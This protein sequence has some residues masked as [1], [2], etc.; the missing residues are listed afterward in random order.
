MQPLDIH[1]LFFHG[2]HIE[3]PKWFAGRQGDIEKALKSLCSPGSSMLVFGERGVGKSS[4]IEMVK[5]IASG[6]NH[7]LFKYNL[8]KLYPPEKFKYRI[9]SVTCD[10]DCTTTAKVLQRLIT[11]PDG[12]K[13]IVSLRQEKIEST[14]KDKFSLDFLKLFTYGT[15]EEKK[16]TSSEIKEDSIFE[17]FINII[18]SISKNVINGNEG[19]LIAIDEF[20]LVSDSSKMASLIK[21]LSKNNVKFLISGIAE[22]YEQLIS[23]HQS[24]FRQLVYG[25]IEI[26]KMTI[27]EVTE[28]FKNVEINSNKRI[29]FDDSFIK[30]VFEK[31]GGYPY[32]VQLLGQLALDNYVS[33]KGLNPPFLFHPQYLKNGLAKLKVF[34]YELEKD[35]VLIVKENSSRELLLKFLARQTSKKISDEIILAYC[36][37]HGITQPEPKY[38]LANFL[39]QRDPQFL[40]REREDSEFV[41]FADPLF[42]IYTNS[43]EPDFLRFEDGQYII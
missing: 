32:F 9:V 15:E 1:S 20:D 19:L 38:L 18:L 29:K 30:E 10:A 28:I 34:E 24:I 22:S 11:S 42:K 4:F 8:H 41:S 6:K 16:I 5:Q 33:L 7:L 36:H 37:K 43:R 12:L 17:L 3:D 14:V 26:I 27:E 25:R 2:Q 31:S 13:S 40:L 21:N 39:A 23:G 35:Y